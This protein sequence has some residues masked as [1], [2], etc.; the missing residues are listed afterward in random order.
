VVAPAAKIIATNT[1]NR[2]IPPEASLSHRRSVLT[3]F[4]PCH[5]K[6]RIDSRDPGCMYSGHSEAICSGDVLG[7]RGN[8]VVAIVIE[9]KTTCF[10]SG[11]DVTRCPCFNIDDAATCG[12]SAQRAPAPCD[13]PARRATATTGGG[14]DGA[15]AD[16]LRSTLENRSAIK[17][18]ACAWIAIPPAMPIPWPAMVAHSSNG[19]RPTKV[20]LATR[21]ET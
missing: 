15:S 12:I 6:S 4:P 10:T 8:A 18:L 14:V 9:C 3:G 21:S 20:A 19:R 1:R 7:G 17:Q 13:I 16:D 2:M 11:T 5:R